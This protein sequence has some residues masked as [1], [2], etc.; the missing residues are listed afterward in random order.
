[1][2][3]KVVLNLSDYLID[4]ALAVREDFHSIKNWE[5][6]NGKMKAATVDLKAK[7]QEKI[8]KKLERKKLKK[9]KNRA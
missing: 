9:R 3:Q 5:M 4:F 7:K 2:L 1:M 6:G 8:L